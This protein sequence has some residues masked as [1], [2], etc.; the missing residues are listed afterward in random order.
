M[1]TNYFVLQGYHFPHI[2]WQLIEVSAEHRN[3]ISEN[4]DETFDFIQHCSKPVDIPEEDAAIYISQSKI[5]LI[6]TI[7]IFVTIISISITNI[8]IITTTN[9]ITTITIILILI[10]VMMMIIIII[11]SSIIVVIGIIMNNISGSSSS[12]SSSSCTVSYTNRGC[13]HIYYTNIFQTETGGQIVLNSS[14]VKPT[15]VSSWYAVTNTA[16]R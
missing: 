4:H 11:S 12:S 6:V 2:S 9:I 14:D 13:H 8:N 5:H 3:I 15:F 1:I 16:L 7:V 10:I